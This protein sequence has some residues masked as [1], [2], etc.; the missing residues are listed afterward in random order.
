MHD[1]ALYIYDSRNHHQRS[2]NESWNEDAGPSGL[3]SKFLVSTKYQ[4]FSFHADGSCRT[5][6]AFIVSMAVLPGDLFGL[7]Y[8]TTDVNYVISLQVIL[9]FLVIYAT[10]PALLQIG[11]RFQTG[12]NAPVIGE[13]RNTMSGSVN[14][15]AKGPMK[16]VGSESR[17]HEESFGLKSFGNQQI[18]STV[19]TSDKLS[20]GRSRSHS[21]RPKRKE[22][23]LEPGHDGDG[24]SVASDSSQK[25]IISKTV[26]QSSINL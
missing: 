23:G 9:L 19:S 3:L 18:V 25:I 4:H 15:T 17:S 6:A 2:P 7:Q 12:Y 8:T 14:R 11:R 1:T 21:K 5:I 20:R 13:H 16:P 22:G 10:T 26:T 24:I